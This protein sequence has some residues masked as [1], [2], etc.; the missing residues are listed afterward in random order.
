MSTRIPRNAPL[1]FA[2]TAGEA[3]KDAAWS[4]PIELP[5][6]GPSLVRSLVGWVLGT[7][8]ATGLWT[9]IAIGLEAAF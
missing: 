9:L 5:Q 4:N 2:R 7:I 6:E 3:F 8:V 1:R